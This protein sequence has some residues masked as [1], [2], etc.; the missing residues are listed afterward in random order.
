MR[1]TAGDDDL[2]SEVYNG[3]E[4][5]FNARLPSHATLFGGWTLERNVVTRCDTPTNYRNIAAVSR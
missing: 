1:N 4:S 3:F 5:S 2:Y